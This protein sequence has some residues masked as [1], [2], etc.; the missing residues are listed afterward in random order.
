MKL[1]SPLNSYV[2][3]KVGPQ[4]SETKNKI[5][6][7]EMKFL[8]EVKDCTRLDKH[9][10]EDIWRNLKIFSLND[11]ILEDEHKWFR[12]VQRM[13]NGKD[14]STFEAETGISAYTMKWGV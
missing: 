7:A 12:Y 9:W 14:G 6:A 8:R 2:D 4:H 11:R 10:N 3:V 1:W 5:Q 13:D